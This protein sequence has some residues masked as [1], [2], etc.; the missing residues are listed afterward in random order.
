MAKSGIRLS[1]N[2]LIFIGAIT[3]IAI[4]YFNGTFA[5]LGISAPNLPTGEDG[6]VTVTKPL[7]FVVADPL[8][9]TGKILSAT[10]KLYDG[11]TL[12][13]TL[14]TDGT[15]GLATT[16]IGYPSG[17]VF[18]VQVSKA[19]YVTRWETVPVPKMTSD[20]AQ[21]LTVNPIQLTTRTLGTYAI[22]VQ[23]SAGTA[24][25]TAD[26]INMT[27]YAS[28]P[29]QLTVTLRNSVD[30]TGYISSYDPVSKV[31]LN[32]ALLTSSSTSYMTIQNAGSYVP[33]GTVSNWVLVPT[34]GGL[35][36]ELVGGIY[37]QQG[38]QSFTI[39]LY[40]GTLTSAAN[41]TVTFDL[42]KYFDSSYYAQQG[43]GGPD[44]AT[45]A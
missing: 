15:T 7:Q 6:K 36:K 38:S 4:L 20:D 26:A 29:M 25:T 18:N 34:D 11:T 44:A 33:R 9:G 28:T 12:A 27:N 43:I 39:T 31:N 24:Y 45:A 42:Y 40:K 16:G 37:K 32:P 8:G 10:I 35:T 5:N 17:K 22:T 1:R 30:N 41:Q 3:L 2:T 13:D 21:A 19:G 23:N 14:T